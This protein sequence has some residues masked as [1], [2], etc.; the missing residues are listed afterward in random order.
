VQVKSVSPGPAGSIITGSR[1]NRAIVF[2]RDPSTTKVAYVPSAVITHHNFVN[3]VASVPPSSQFPEGLAPL[4]FLFFFLFFFPIEI[5]GSFPSKSSLTLFPLFPSFLP[6][7]ALLGLVLS[8]G[9]ENIIYAHAPSN[10]AVPVLTLIGHTDNVCALAVAGTPEQPIIISGSWD[11]T[12]RVWAHGHCVQ[13]LQGHELAVWSV[14][15]LDNGDI[16]TG[17]ADKTIRLWRDGHCVKT[18]TG[19]ADCVRGL[20]ILKSIGFV[21]SSNDG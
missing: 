12:C 18:I 16:L 20:A 9:R 7:S 10:P 14:L 19:H 5:G 17:S 13:T 6:P 2:T 1:D 11:K 4:F 3:A 15:G 21:S 8:A